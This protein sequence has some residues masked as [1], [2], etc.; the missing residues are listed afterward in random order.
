M[1]LR[2]RLAFPK[3]DNANLSAAE[4]ANT[5]K[6]RLQVWR[7]L[8][9]VNLGCV[10]FTSLRMRSTQL[11]E[12][13]WSSKEVKKSAGCSIH[14][15]KR[16]DFQDPKTQN[17][18][19]MVWRIDAVSYSILLR[20]T[21]LLWNLCKRLKPTY[22]MNVLNTLSLPQS[23]AWSNKFVGRVSEGRQEYH[24]VVQ[25]LLCFQV[26]L[27]SP[28]DAWIRSSKASQDAQ[29]VPENFPK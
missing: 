9:L 6:Y 24:P 16:T 28:L 25:Q 14:R 17:D 19:L 13:G 22:L 29:S 2:Y 20:E 23:N 10:P 8:G 5:R 15:D 11:G 26:L 18:S 4:T 1:A 27:S 3:P 12:E 21:H 7:P